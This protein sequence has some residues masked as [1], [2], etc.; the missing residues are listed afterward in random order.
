MGIEGDSEVSRVGSFE[1]VR[2]SDWE[3]CWVTT[4]PGGKLVE[5]G[6]SNTE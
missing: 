4:M 2:R 5:V 3:L 6:C 1:D